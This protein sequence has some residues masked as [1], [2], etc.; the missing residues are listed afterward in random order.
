MNVVDQIMSQEFQDLLEEDV[1][2]E[3]IMD[4][5]ELTYECGG[6]GVPRPRSEL[7]GAYIGGYGSAVSGFKVYF[8]DDSPVRNLDLDT[9]DIPQVEAARIEYKR[10]VKHSQRAT[11]IFAATA[12]GVLLPH[13]SSYQGNDDESDQ[14]M[15]PE[16]EALLRGDPEPTVIFK[17]M[18]R[19]YHESW[20]QFTVRDNCARDNGPAFLR[21][22]QDLQ[23]TVRHEMTLGTHSDDAKE[24]ARNPENFLS[25]ITDFMAQGGTE[26][27]KVF[28]NFLLYGRFSEFTE[29][30]IKTDR[31]RSMFRSNLG[32]WSA[33]FLQCNPGK[34]SSL[35]YADDRFMLLLRK[36]LSM[37]QPCVDVIRKATCSC[38]HVGINED[39]CYKCFSGG[40]KYDTHAT[41]Q[42]AVM[43][44]QKHAGISSTA[45]DRNLVEGDGQRRH[46]DTT[47]HRVKLDKSRFNKFGTDCTLV[48]PE[49][50]TAISMRYCGT[51]AR[52]AEAVKRKSGDTEENLNKAGMAYFPLAVES[53]GALGKQIKPFIKKLSEVGFVRRRHN[54][55]YFNHWW[56][57]VIS[58]TIHQAVADQI[59]TKAMDML[60]SQS[61]VGLP[62]NLPTGSF[63]D[64]SAEGAL[65]SRVL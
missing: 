31:I 9:I 30:T 48:S 20:V 58:N 40:D 50:G 45:E 63:G 52:R 3:R 61:Q 15:D 37:K 21:M 44:A 19:L 12:L 56:E 2:L 10:I 32:E 23:S 65:G 51:A 6:L 24:K 25:L 17:K 11:D 13:T 16:Y 27:Q 34:H 8:R 55:A 28:G 38:G 39:H 46:A 5:S 47:G 53:N 60:G 7:P 1:L 64:S 22:D 54:K 26:I 59:L 41:M 4:Q 18:N 36:R 35:K 42:M 43:A 62:F 49:L 33:T 57:M 14:G 29:R